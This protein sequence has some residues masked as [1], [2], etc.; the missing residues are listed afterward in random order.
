MHRDA[1]GAANICSKQVFGRVGLV[2]VCT[3]MHRRPVAVRAPTRANM[4]ALQA[5]RWQ[6]GVGHSLRDKTLGIYGY[7]R[8]G[9]VVAGY[10]KAFGMHVVAWAREASLAQARD[11]GYTVARSKAS[12]FEECDVISLH[13]RLVEA[14]RGIVIATDLASMKPTALL[15]NASRAGLIEPGALVTALRTGRPGMAAVDVYAD[16]SLRDLHHPLLT[17]PNVVCT[18]HIGYVTH[19]EYEIQFADIFDQITAYAEDAPIN[20]VNP[21]VL[22]T[23]GAQR[24]RGEREGKAN[25]GE[26]VDPL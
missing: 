10:G 5:G 16:E 17:I 11:D 7:G 19:D 9:R 8:I 2:Q 3:L 22:P 14:T 18:P 26:A 20:V 13:M 4:A 1:N 21:E 6:V 24:L 25:A 15:V 12:F 23:L